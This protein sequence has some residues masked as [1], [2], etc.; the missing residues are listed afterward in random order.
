[1]RLLQKKVPRTVLITLLAGTSNQVFGQPA[2]SRPASLL[3]GKKAPQ[4]SLQ[5]VKG[6][7]I[8]Q[9]E[10]SKSAAT[11]LN[12][13]APNCGFCKKQIPVVEAARKEFQSKGIRFINIIVTMRKEFPR[14]EVM[15]VFDELGSQLELAIDSENAIAKRYRAESYPTLFV[16]D[17]DGNVADV[18]MGAKHD[19]GNVLRVRLDGL[20]SG[21]ESADVGPQA[22]SYMVKIPPA[23]DPRTPPS[24]VIEPTRREP[25]TI[26][27][28]LGRPESGKSIYHS[29]NGKG[30]CEKGIDCPPP[31][32]YK[33][34]AGYRYVKYR[35]D[36]IN[37]GHKH[38]YS[39][40]WDDD[41]VYVD[42]WANGN[43][44]WK[45]RGG[46]LSF[47]LYVTFEEI[48]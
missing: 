11:V 25:R 45:R 9:S 48:N 37:A 5:T 41:W 29:R 10:F 30:N 24:V 38:G 26:E 31:L 34:P 6:G 13:V 23:F 3:I 27:R 22:Q 7:E 4:F 33:I 32:K 42:I 2:P 47:D 8:G 36:N 14:D 44:R 1:M 19:L 40:T 17:K 21:D 28:L 43:G 20:L 12:F 15:R 35:I 46:W 39:L 18:L 16:V